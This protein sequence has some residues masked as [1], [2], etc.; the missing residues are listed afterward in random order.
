VLAQIGLTQEKMFR[1]S[2]HTAAKQAK[3]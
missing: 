2:G 3:A 1:W